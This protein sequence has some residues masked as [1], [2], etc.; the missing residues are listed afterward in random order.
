MA[1]M[2]SR[3]RGNAGSNKPLTKKIP[4]WVQ[5]KEK[6]LEMLIVKLSKEGNSPSKIGTL[7]RDNYGVPDAELILKKKITQVLREKDLAPEFPEDLSALITKAVMLKKHLKE[8]NKDQT[9]RFGLQLTESKIKRLVKY[10]KING[11]LA[12]EWKYNPEELGLLVE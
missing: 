10:Y 12:S 2:H 1:R 8:N 4:S 9:A 7:L 3:K 6:E 5:I 11:K